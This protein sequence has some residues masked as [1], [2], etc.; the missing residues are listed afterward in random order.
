MAARMEIHGG[1]PSLEIAASENKVIRTVCN[2]PRST[3]THDL[4]MAFKIPYL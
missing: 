1:Q 2:S 3:P 4:H